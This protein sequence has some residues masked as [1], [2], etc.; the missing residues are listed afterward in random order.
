MQSDFKG[1]E[2]K[3][4]SNRSHAWVEVFYKGRGWV[5]IEATPSPDGGTYTNV[6]NML[7]D[8]AEDLPE[9]ETDEPIDP[10]Q[11]SD[12]EDANDENH[13]NISEENTV[14]T[15]FK[16]RPAIFISF[17]FLILIAAYRLISKNRFFYRIQKMEPNQQVISYY[18][19]LLKIQ[20]FGST[21]DQELIE[22]VQKAKFSQHTI[23]HEELQ[24]VQE[25]STLYIKK[26]YQALPWYKKIIYKYILGY[27]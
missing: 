6:G 10:N 14:N 3:V 1:E 4:L 16:D 2:A 12:K 19:H 5:P 20:R 15:S 17:I 7:D 26:T 25:I 8:I 11:P 27:I 23:N 18:Q 21:I 13:E 22:L 9:I 24:K